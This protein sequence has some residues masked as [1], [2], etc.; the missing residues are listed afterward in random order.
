LRQKEEVEMER[1]HRKRSDATQA[2][3]GRNPV[4]DRDFRFDLRFRLTTLTRFS[5]AF[6]VAVFF[7]EADFPAANSRCPL[8]TSRLLLLLSGLWL[9]FWPAHKGF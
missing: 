6:A 7:T 1:H 5:Q 2:I 8:R 9:P 4:F 3:Q